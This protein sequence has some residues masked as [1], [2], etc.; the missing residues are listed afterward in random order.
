M[1]FHVPGL[2]LQQQGKITPIMLSMLLLVLD[3]LYA[4][5][6]CMLTDVLTRS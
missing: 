6:G 3:M 2:R 1:L 4:V 5:Y